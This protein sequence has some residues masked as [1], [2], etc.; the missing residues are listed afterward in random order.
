[1]S[2]ARPLRRLWQWQWQ[3]RDR[4]TSTVAPVEAYR[5]WAGTYGDQPNALQQI[6]A[7]TLERVM[8][9]VAGRRVLDIGCGKAR[10]AA[11]AV[12][13]GATTAF[14]TDRTLAMLVSPG[15][16]PSGAIRRLAAATHP[17]PFRMHQFDVVLCN[18]VLGHVRDIDRALEAMARVLAVGG[19]L[20]ITDFHPEA[21]RRGWQRTFQD[22][23]GNTRIIEQHLH[24]LDTYR[25]TLARLGLV[26]QILDEPCWEGQPVILGLRAHKPTASD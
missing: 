26:L 24:T 9:P 1:M 13:K 10:A 3:W 5:Q 7:D 16:H 4:T 19:D 23:A 8:P 11:G 25:E 15:R 21:T 18:L 22:D 17:L 14:A 20:V 2:A 6:E 12:A